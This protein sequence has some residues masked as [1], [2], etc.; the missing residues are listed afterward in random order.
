M[1]RAR[2]DA[3]TR[4]E[5]AYL[6][7]FLDAGH[8]QEIV[9]STAAPNAIVRPR[10]NVAVWLPNNVTL[11]GPLTLILLSL[12]GNRIFMKEGSRADALTLAFA[13]YVREH[14]GAAL[15]E[16][17]EI[18]RAER[19]DPA[20]LERTTQADVVIVFGSDEAVAAA[21]QHVRP[22]ATLIPFSDR[23]SEAWLAGSPTDEV[24]IDLIKVFAV[25]GQAGCTSPARV[26]VLDG[27]AEEVRDRIVRLWPERLRNREPHVASSNVLAAQLAA[28]AGWAAALAP[29]NSAVIA[30]G[31]AAL[32]IPQAGL[33]LPIVALSVEEAIA[34]MPP[35]I[36]T[37]GHDADPALAL[38]WLAGTP[39][40]RI[41][42]I[43]AMHH[44]GPVW[45]GR[46][47]LRECLEWIEVG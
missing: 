10:G 7:A 6:I 22:G 40:K 1:I 33:F 44:F 43:A 35:N 29:A 23:R 16:R 27:D 11:L 39:V 42:P 3:F 47:W 34:S 8:L 26:V 18:V 2:P 31:S 20:V 4:D 12:T 5:W 46:E 30:A 24:L 25:Y 9:R 14:G 17:A 37:V 13:D 28:A 19:N 38:Q 36:Q 45:D 15:L 41:V 21:S 32:E